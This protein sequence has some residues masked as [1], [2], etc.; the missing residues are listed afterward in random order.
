MPA[1]QNHRL[2]PGLPSLPLTER[3]RLLPL[4][5]ALFLGLVLACALALPVSSLYASLADPDATTV[6]GYL[7][8]H[9]VLLAGIALFALFLA[10]LALEPPRSTSPR[11]Y[12][13]Q[14]EARWRRL[15]SHYDAALARRLEEHH[16]STSVPRR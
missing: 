13:S 9:S 15:Q 14:L 6:F 10:L 11:A 2:A 3:L 1:D 5:E 16:D 4:P 12:L 7:G 8:R